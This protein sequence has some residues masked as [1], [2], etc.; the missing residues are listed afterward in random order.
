MKNK[1]IISIIALACIFLLISY[2]L[3]GQNGEVLISDQLDSEEI[4]NNN[5]Y[6]NYLI[7]IKTDMGEIQFETYADDAPNTVENFIALAEKGFYDGVIFHRVIDGFMIQGGDPTGTGRGGPGYSFN[8]EIDPS[9]KIYQDGYQKGVVAMANA[10]PNTQGSQFFIMVVD[11]PLPPAYTIFGKVTA[12]QEVADSIS[13]VEKD[14]SDKPI[15]DVVI[16]S[17]SVLEKE[18]R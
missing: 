9:S 15:K 7:T 8:D 12:G 1:T 5:K 10:G 3:S 11:Y 16:E 4:I 13:R 14:S 17:I 18:D 6:M 2:Y